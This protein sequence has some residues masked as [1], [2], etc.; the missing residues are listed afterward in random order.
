MEPWTFCYQ[1][2]DVKAKRICFSKVLYMA[3]ALA[4]AFILTYTVCELTFEIDYW[5]VTL[6]WNTLAIIL[7]LALC[8][9]LYNIR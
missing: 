5:A 8:I 2:E 1:T 3:D 6:F 7:T 9:A 4:C